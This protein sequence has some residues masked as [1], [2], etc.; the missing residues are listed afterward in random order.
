MKDGAPN[1]PQS[2][3]GTNPRQLS[4]LERIS[5]ETQGCSEPSNSD[6]ATRVDW[7]LDV[8]PSIKLVANMV[9]PSYPNHIPA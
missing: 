4:K 1:S 3:S 2:L 6:H 8:R 7:Y 9:N 5:Y